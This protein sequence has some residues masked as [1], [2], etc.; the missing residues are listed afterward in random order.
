MRAK[1]AVA[2]V[3]ALDAES[4]EVVARRVAELMRGSPLPGDVDAA[5]VA[6][7]LGVERDW[8]YR[9]AARLGARRLGS[10]QRAR[11]RFELDL[12]VERARSMTA[13]LAGSLPEQAENGTGKRKTGR[14]RG[15]E[16]RQRG[17]LLPISGPVPHG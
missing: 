3:V 15:T 13:S 17:E 9:R 12:A 11:L 10:G 8:V 2:E 14:P 6:R 16:K 4:I 5:T 1:L 7:V